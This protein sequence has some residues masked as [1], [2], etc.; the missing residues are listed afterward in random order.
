MSLLKDTIITVFT[1][2]SCPTEN[3]NFKNNTESSLYDGETNSSYTD[4]ET[5]SSYT[6]GETNSFYTDGETNSFYTDG[7]TNS[8]YNV[9]SLPACGEGW[10]GVKKIPV[11]HLKKGD[12]IL[13]AS[14]KT[15]K[16]KNLI[17]RNYKGRI[18]ILN[19]EKKYKPFPITPNHLI[20]SRRIKPSN[21]TSDTEKNFKKMIRKRAKELRKNMTYTEKL[22]WNKI[23]KRQL[24][25]KFRRQHAIGKYIPDF[26]SPEIALV[27]E[28]DGDAHS[29]PGRKEKDIDKDYFYRSMAIDVLRIYDSEI[30]DNLDG[31]VCMIHS[32]IKEKIKDTERVVKWCSAK[33]LRAGDRVVCGQEL[34]I[35]NISYLE[36]ML[37]DEEVYDINI[38][39]SDSIIT[40]SCI[41]HAL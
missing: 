15:Q 13:D 4:G 34:E 9:L 41:V 23:R 17:S 7:E 14:K 8:F 40:E 16:I 36:E 37:V 32:I 35:I 19:F 6:D 5:N 12:L 27:I 10:G 30:I 2:A 1:D 20:L 21:I 26:Y 28:I 3:T 29:I 31:V 11:Q 24:G 22:L 25:V 33:N 39:S 18:I 38:D